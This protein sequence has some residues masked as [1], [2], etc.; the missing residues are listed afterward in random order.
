MV[1]L[2]RWISS[3]RRETRAARCSEAPPGQDGTYR[4]MI[5]WRIVQTGEEVSA[6]NR[7]L[8]E[9]QLLAIFI[10]EQMFRFRPIS[11]VWAAAVKH[12]FT[13]ALSFWGRPDLSTI[14]LTQ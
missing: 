7:R 3:T 13:A 9:S 4:Q 1:V 12:S 2:A 6:V 14:T 8:N 11:A 5:Q 10:R